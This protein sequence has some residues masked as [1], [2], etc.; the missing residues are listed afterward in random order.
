M[1]MVMVMVRVRMTKN[2]LHTQRAD[3]EMMI[4]DKVID[5][6]MLIRA[7]YMHKQMFTSFIVCLQT[8]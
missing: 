6:G 1:V 8:L 4:R 2:M 7:S 5:R 3:T